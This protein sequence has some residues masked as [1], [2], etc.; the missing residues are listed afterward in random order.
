VFHVQVNS[1]LER[2][3]GYTQYEFQGMAQLRGLFG[4]LR[5]ETFSNGTRL[6]RTRENCRPALIE[7]YIEF[8]RGF[9]GLRAS[10]ASSYR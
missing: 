1:D 9:I 6:T 7:D 10:R 8:V 3:L 4:V 2:M 5:S